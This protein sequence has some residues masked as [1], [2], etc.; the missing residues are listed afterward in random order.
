MAPDCFVFFLLSLFV[1]ARGQSEED[2]T[3]ERAERLAEMMKHDGVE[4]V[5]QV[6][7][8]SF[9][10]LVKKNDIIVMLFHAQQND[11]LYKQEKYALEVR[12]CTR[13]SF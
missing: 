9:K 3:T 13:F 11:S 5:V 4:R 12:N 8:K 7:P 2:G 10:G 6:T 1:I